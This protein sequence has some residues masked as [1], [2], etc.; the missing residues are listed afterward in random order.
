MA[1]VMDEMIRMVEDAWGVVRHAPPEA[2]LL[3]AVSIIV[4]GF[5][6][7]SPPAIPITLISI[8]MNP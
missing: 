8:P 4:F 7:V 1:A 2:L 6:F 3:A 5:A